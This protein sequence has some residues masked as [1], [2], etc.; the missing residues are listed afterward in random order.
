MSETFFVTDANGTERW[1]V[2]RNK[3]NVEPGLAKAFAN[4]H[5][6]KSAGVA[7]IGGD[8]GSA[9]ISVTADMSVWTVPI[10][11][12]ALKTFYTLEGGVHRPS[13]THSG[14]V[15]LPMKWTP[16]ST[17][18][19]GLII[20]A[21]KDGR[22]YVAGEQFLMAVD[23]SGRVYRLPI[24]NIN[25]ACQ[26]CHGQGHK[27]HDSQLEAVRSAC[28]GMAQST[29]NSDMYGEGYENASEH[30][31]ALFQWKPTKDGFEQ[32]PV[33][34]TWQNYCQKVSNDFINQHMM[35]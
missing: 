4:G 35:L 22:H 14:N 23:T 2:V 27:Y 5:C 16:P 26:L 34:T 18:K 29:W 19:L 13:F 20:A 15:E 7:E 6:L 25:S 24:G 32:L 3:V 9:N 12:L 33:P 10:L 11:K 1:T 21:R 28:K 30:T 17:M 31:N 8:Y